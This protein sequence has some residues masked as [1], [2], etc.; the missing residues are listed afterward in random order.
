MNYLLSIPKNLKS[1]LRKS[2]KNTKD[3]RKQILRIP[4]IR[5]KTQKII[6]RMKKNQTTKDKKT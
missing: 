4:K 1:T 6:L 2:L 3:K 5:C